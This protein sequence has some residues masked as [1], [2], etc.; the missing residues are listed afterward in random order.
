MPKTRAQKTETVQSIKE[1]LAGM[2]SVV[3]ANFEQ[4]PTKDIESVRWELKKAGAIYTVA[5]KTLLR[6]AFKD[7]GVQVDPKTIPGNFATII[8]TEDEA[9]PAKI[10][11]L[12]SKNHPALKLI[13]GVLEGKLLDAAGVKALAALPGKKELQARLVGSLASPISGLVNVLVGNLR[14]LVTV[15]SAIKDKKTV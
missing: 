5:K 14:G 15:L 13:A 7:A 6:L 1:K 8:G 9:A 4:L 11:A 12:F 10:L 2:R 3:F